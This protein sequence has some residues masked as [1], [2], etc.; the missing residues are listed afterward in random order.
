MLVMSLAD[1]VVGV[2]VVRV[3][4]MAV[5]QNLAIMGVQV[6]VQNLLS[7]G[8][9]VGIFCANQRVLP[10]QMGMKQFRFSPRPDSKNN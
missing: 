5:L 4:M 2:M 8:C 6:S 7:S 3:M 9:A 1:T 10:G